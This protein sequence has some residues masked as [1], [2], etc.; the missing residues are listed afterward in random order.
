MEGKRFGA[1]L[2]AGLLLGLVIVTASSGFAF[3]LYGSFTSNAGVGLA[4]STTA[5]STTTA[6]SQPQYALNSTLASN[7]RSTTTTTTG[8]PPSGADY[9][10]L[11]APVYSSH[12]ANIAQQPVLTN[13]IIF[14]PVLVAFLLGAVLYRASMKRGGDDAQEQSVP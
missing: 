1:G 13:A 7:G 4:P 9:A 11:N 2:V 10:T 3:G 14:L 6:S 8:S 12:V 5:K